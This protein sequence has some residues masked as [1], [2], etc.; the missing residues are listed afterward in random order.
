MGLTRQPRRPI[1]AHEARRPRV[2]P[3]AKA[4][5]QEMSWEMQEDAAELRMH[6]DFNRALANAV[7]RCYRRFAGRGPTEAKVVYQGNVVVVVLQ[8]VL[9]VAERTL[10]ADGRQAEVRQFRDALH[11]TMGAE[12]AE[13]I[14]TL[15][16]CHV[17]AAMS[18]H[19]VDRD[20]AAELFM[21]ERDATPQG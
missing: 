13:M 18:A 8:G 2:R 6:A 15:T 20:L 9:T 1:D 7:V 4:T 17:R 21:L 11:E 5:P 16:G 14:E 3:R 12:L 19:D 10:V